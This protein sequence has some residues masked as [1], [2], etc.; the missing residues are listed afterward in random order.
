[1]EHSGFNVFLYATILWCISKL[2]Y[3]TIYRLYLCPV[4]A[5][6]GPRLA[7]LTYWYEFYHDIIH[8]GQ[9]LWRVGEMHEKYGP[10]VRVNPH[11]IHIN[12]PEF[13]D[14]L[15]AN[16]K[17]ANKWEWQAQQFGVP[18][19]LISTVD[20]ETHRMRRGV[21]NHFFSMQRV[22]E[23]QPLIQERADVL[24]Q[25]VMEPQGTGKFIQWEHACAAL[26]NGRCSMP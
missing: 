9:Y 18:L 10:I 1:M 8:R 20:H 25:R 6:P 15:Y 26:A 17:P 19:S 4:A 7:A 16:N 3:G 11:E 5:I 12:D 14:K 2:A 23:L 21:L 22:R 13:Y 24:I